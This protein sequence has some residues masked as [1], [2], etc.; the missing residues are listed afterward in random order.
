M[1]TVI[2]SLL[3]FVAIGCGLIAGLYF[4][5]STFIMTALGRMEAAQG[6][7]AMNS[8]NSTIVGSLFMPLFFGTTI[9]AA[10]LAAFSL[11]RWS[12]PGS[13]AMLA[14]G[15][16]YLIGMF[17]CTIVY[18]V[19]LNNELE[20]NAAGAADVWVRY[21]KDWTFWNHIRTVASTAAMVFFI[22]ALLAGRSD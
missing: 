8:I 21:L 4:A 11:L 6:V 3:W 19:P 15:L 14:G 2:T 13:A 9:A 10:A 16:T 22:V 5:F 18:N 20:R 12:E 1:Q 17:G 7:A